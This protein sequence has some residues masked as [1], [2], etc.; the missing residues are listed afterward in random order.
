ME[1]D[2]LDSNIRFSN[3]YESH[4]M[5][6]TKIY[7]VWTTMK[8]RCTDIK[9]E[10]YVRY[11]GRW[12]SYDTKWEK[13]L[14]FYEDMWA[15]YKEWLEIERENNDWNYCKSNCTWITKQ[16]QARNRRSNIVF[17]NKT[18]IEWSE[19]RGIKAKTIYQRLKRGWNIE[20]AIFTSLIL[21][22]ENYGERITWF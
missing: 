6:N 5:S 4:W 17:K 22:H 11:W 9:S 21:N 10:W 1:Q 15:S 7:K 12:I 14:W 3:T 13:F 16:K 18:I 20:D 19:I 8:Q 2:L